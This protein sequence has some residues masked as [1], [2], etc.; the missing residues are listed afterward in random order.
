[1]KNIKSILFVAL[2]IIGIS[3]NN[4]ELKAE[5]PTGNW[6]CCQDISTGCI[7]ILGNHW[8]DDYL[9]NAGTCTQG[10]GGIGN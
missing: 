3:A 1:M 4:T 2:F 7:D 5:E 9:K 8:P 6:V 10:T